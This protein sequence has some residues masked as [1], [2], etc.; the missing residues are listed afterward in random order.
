MND[1]TKGRLGKTRR[2]V[3]VTISERF[4]HGNHRITE[5]TVTHRH[6]KSGHHMNSGQLRKDSGKAR[7]GSGQMK[8]R[9]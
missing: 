3:H 7:Y 4:V 8:R 9:G 6:G 1:N 2:S 5:A